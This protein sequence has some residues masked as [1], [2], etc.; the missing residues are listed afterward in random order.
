VKIGLI[1]DGD[2]EFRSL[3]HLIPKIS[4]PHVIFHN[5]LR[6]PVHGAMPPGQI[7][8]QVVSRVKIFSA[9]GANKVIIA[10]DREDSETCPGVLAQTIAAACARACSRPGIVVEV[11]IKDRMFENWLIADV[12]ALEKFPRRFGITEKF[13]RAVVPNKADA[14]PALRMLE[15]VSKGDSFHKVDDAIKIC[16]AARPEN[17]AKESRSFRRFLRIVEHPD[18]QAQSRQP[19]PSTPR[20][21]V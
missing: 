7:A 14:V 18:Y 17:I 6:V 21:G 9:R 13:R 11:L 5:P 3:P 15:G 12:T 2:A 19:C 4:T 8:A 16:R 10:L 20:S 1:V